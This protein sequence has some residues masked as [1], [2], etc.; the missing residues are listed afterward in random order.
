M[1]IG[2]GLLQQIAHED[3]FAPTDHRAVTEQTGGISSF[4]RYASTPLD[5]I[6]RGSRFQYL[7]GYYPSTTHA[8]DVHRT[9]RVEVN[10]RDVTTQYRHGYRLAPSINDEAEFRA[11]AAEYRLST[12]LTRLADTLEETGLRRQGFR[13]TPSLRI[14]A[15]RIEGS[16]ELKVSLALNPARVSF[17][18]DD[19]KRVVLHLAIVLDDA[20]GVAVGELTRTVELALSGRELANAKNQWI[21]F[22]VLVPFTGNPAQVRAAVYDYDGDGIR[23]GRSVIADGK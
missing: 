13:R 18:G 17:A 3:F 14:T 6:E 21:E 19:S 16:S 8:P 5:R 11:A 9:V 4:Y 12:E 22:D 20:N 23:S 7:L 2:R 15:Q 10:R 1:G